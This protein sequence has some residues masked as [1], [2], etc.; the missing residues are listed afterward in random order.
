MFTFVCRLLCDPVI[1]W[2]M[3]CKETFKNYSTLDTF[4]M[5][6]FVSLSHISF[7]LALVLYITGLKCGSSLHLYHSGPV[8]NIGMIGRDYLFLSSLFFFY[9]FLVLWFIFS[10]YIMCTNIDLWWKWMLV[11]RFDYC[12]IYTEYIQCVNLS[13]KK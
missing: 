9:F 4:Y 6:W 11:G 7:N 13:T 12:F 10:R 5:L 3:L 1:M 2:G 8:L